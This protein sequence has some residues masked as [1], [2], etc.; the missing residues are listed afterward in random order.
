M[1]CNCPSQHKAKKKPLA[2]SL[3]VKDEGKADEQQ[4]TVKIE[5]FC[6]SKIGKQAPA[7]VFVMLHF[8]RQTLS[9]QKE[10]AGKI[11]L[12]TKREICLVSSCKTR[13]LTVRMYL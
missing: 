8:I 5:G 12:D 3:Y 9:I 6:L 10:P 13:V 7:E 4:D 2:K 1:G 11:P